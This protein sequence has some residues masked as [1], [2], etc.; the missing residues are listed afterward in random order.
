LSTVYNSGLSPSTAVVVTNRLPSDATIIGI[1]SSRG[2]FTNLSNNVICNF[3]DLA[4]GGSA[5]LQVV[6]TLN[7]P[8][9]MTNLA[10]VS[11]STPDPVATNNFASTTVEFDSI[12]TSDLSIT[13]TSPS[14]PGL[15]G[16]NL[17]Y[18]LVVSNAGPAAAAGVLL[19]DS[20][21]PGATV[22]SAALPVP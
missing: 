11:Q 1:T 12:P 14:A 5:W 4:I 3:G 2:T 10:N 17:V 9:T 22:I 6:A 7:Q 16:S 18:T 13:Q 21:P 20:F 19:T 15:V 8:G